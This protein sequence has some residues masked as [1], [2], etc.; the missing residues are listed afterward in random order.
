M[1]LSPDNNELIL[2]FMVFISFNMFP[3]KE[4]IIFPVLVGRWE[5][6]RNSTKIRPFQLSHGYICRIYAIHSKL[7]DSSTNIPD[8]K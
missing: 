7:M 1:V 2:Y 5:M 8:V 6:W 4:I 3:V